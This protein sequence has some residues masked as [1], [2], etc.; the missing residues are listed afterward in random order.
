MSSYPLQLP[1][2][3]LAEVRRLAADNQLSLDE[4]LL[5]AIAEKVGAERTSQ[6]L[7]RYAEN[8]NYSR[9]DEILARVPDA[10]PLAGDEFS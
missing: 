1:D 6:L 5:M 4:W 2:G 10:Q 8:A 7:R 3:L 9:F